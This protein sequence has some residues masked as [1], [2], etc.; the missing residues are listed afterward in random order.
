[1]KNKSLELIKNIYNIIKNQNDDNYMT[2]WLIYDLCEK[3][4]KENKILKEGK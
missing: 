2:N 1:M 4:L 3:H